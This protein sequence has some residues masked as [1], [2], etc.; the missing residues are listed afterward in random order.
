M[1]VAPPSAHF[2]PGAQQPWGTS[3]ARPRRRR[4][5]VVEVVLLSL[6]TLGLL[7]FVGLMVLSA[8]AGG[9]AT[10]ALLALFPLLI[11]GAAILW[12][13][14]WEP[15]PRLLLLAAFVWG[16]GVATL[17][18]SFLNSAV[19]PAL[20]G[21]LAPG[22]TP[23]T[24]TA[25][26]GAPVVEELIKGAG[27]LIVFGLRRRQF[28]GP[29]D[30]IVY[31]AVIAAAFAFV[32]NIQYFATAE[33]LG[34][35]F[36]LRGLVSPFGHL[37]YT[38]C[39]GVAL[40]AAARMS[41]PHAWVWLLPVGYVAAVLLHAA[42]NAFAGLAYSLG[43]LV[44]LVV[45]V[46]WLPLVLWAVVVVQLRRHEVRVLAARLAEYVPS[47]WV[48]PQ[49]IAMVTSLRARR[50]ALSW[51]AR[52]GPRVK[53][54]MKTFQKAAVDLAYARQ[55][56]ASG[57]VGVRARRDERALLATMGAARARFRT[58]MGV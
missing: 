38:A 37:I 39:T 31:A 33:E 15:E 44:A 32:E 25:V 45:L 41:R 43:D 30:G 47:G 21:L 1:T 14:R 26:F 3:R 49:E 13:D 20:A 53:K 6:G 28:N 36:V 12:V 24:A 17:A 2:G 48:V 50:A 51:A 35:T 58:A 42:W 23:Q 11:V 29:V 46:N 54:A 4:R 19:G 16:G 8:G 22:M 56:I 52:G 10:A 18:A 5:V 40:G 7:A 34:V 27:V 9:V 57:S 55:D